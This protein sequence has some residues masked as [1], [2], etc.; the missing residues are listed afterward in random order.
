[1]HKQ[2]VYANYFVCTNLQKEKYN[3]I[4]IDIEERIE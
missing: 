3:K 4:F 1:M 2:L